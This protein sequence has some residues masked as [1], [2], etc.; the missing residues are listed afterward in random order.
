MMMIEEFKKN[1]KNSLKEIQ[2]RWAVVAHDFNPST[3]E[4]EAGKFLSSRPSWSTE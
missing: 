2:E 1:I 4:E 3:W